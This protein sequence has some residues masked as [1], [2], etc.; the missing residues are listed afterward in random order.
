MMQETLNAGS[1][2]ATETLQKYKAGFR[3]VCPKCS[4]ELLPIPEGVPRGQRISGLRCPNNPHH[5]YLYEG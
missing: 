3:I 4:A 2:T 5:Y 1:L